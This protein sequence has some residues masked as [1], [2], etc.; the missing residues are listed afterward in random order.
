MGEVMS[1]AKIVAGANKGDKF[2]K[3]EVCKAA[4][5]ILGAASAYGGFDD[6]EGIGSYLSKAEDMLRKYGGG[7][8]EGEG[9]GPKTSVSHS[10]ASEEKKKKSND[11][12]ES[13]GGPKKPTKKDDGE[14]DGGGGVGG[15]LK[16]AQ[17]FWKG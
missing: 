16:M 6:K 4:S 12:N 17:G 10:S 1:S 5:T 8:Q 3:A 15:Y 14:E 11:S 2:D 7:G 9:G 13:G